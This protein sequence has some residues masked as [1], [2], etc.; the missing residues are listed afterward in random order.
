MEKHLP[1]KWISKRVAILLLDK[2]DFKTKTVTR[3]KEGHYTI[4]QEDL[5]VINIYV[6]NMKY[7]NI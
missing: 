2:L 4:Q 3:N 1:H 5:T 7:P 6:A